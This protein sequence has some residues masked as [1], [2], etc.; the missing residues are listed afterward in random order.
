MEE[1]PICKRKKILIFAVV[2]TL[3]L[4]FTAVPVI[5]SESQY[6]VKRGDNLWIIAQRHNITLQELKRANNL[7]SDIIYPQQVLNLPGKIIQTTTATET[8]GTYVVKRGDSLWKIAERHGVTLTALRRTNG[9]TGSLIHPGEKLLIPKR[10]QLAS[11]GMNLNHED[12]YWL[13]RAISAEAKGEPLMGQIAVGA[14]IMNRVEY[15][16]F[17]NSIKDVVFQRVNGVYQFSPVQNGSI[18]KTP[19]KSAYEAAQKALDGEDPT[20]GALYF[21]NPHITASNN[22]IRTRPVA[23]VVNNHVFAL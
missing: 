3:L 18:Y 7:T 13:A 19:V 11:R 23:R 22:W 2:L 12:I 21:Y 4:Q 9:L 1:V 8:S 14:V 5:A 16:Y 17:P 20:N 6:V 15:P 10:I